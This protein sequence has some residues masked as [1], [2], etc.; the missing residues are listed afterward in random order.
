MKKIA[1]VLILFSVLS[2]DARVAINCHYQTKEKIEESYKQSVSNVNSLKLKVK[3]TLALKVYSWGVRVGMKAAL[4]MIRCSE[5]KLS[6]LEFE[7]RD[8]RRMKG[9]LMRT[10]P[11]VGKNVTV[12]EVE[13]LDTNESYSAATIFHEATHKC[14]STDLDYF[15]RTNKP[16]SRR[17]VHWSLIADTYSYWLHY[18]FCIPQVDC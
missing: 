15:D 13:F 11:L 2:I 10:L 5:R 18:G 1:F 12:D 9:K 4:E 14:G 6:K 7:C 17:G 16:R 8:S 3:N